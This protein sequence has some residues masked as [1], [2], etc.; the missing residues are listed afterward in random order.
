MR[1]LYLVTL[2][3]LAAVAT[4]NG[5]C[6]GSAGGGKATGDYLT[7]GICVTTSTCNHVSDVT[8]FSFDLL[9]SGPVQENDS[10]LD[11]SARLL[12]TVFPSSKF[13]DASSTIPTN[14]VPLILSQYKGHYIS[15]GCPYDDN[16]V[17]CCLIGLDQSAA[18]KSLP[19]FPSRILLI[20][21]QPIPI[22]E[23]PN[24]TASPSNPPKGSC[25]FELPSPKA[26]RPSQKTELTQDVSRS[27]P[28]RRLFLL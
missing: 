10:V 24:L 13:P 16:D 12:R 27:Q 6:S 4:L 9:P 19:S 22:T 23:S 1:S 26:T 11:M 25:G 14:N 7:D 18:S 17:K 3:P 5:H 15:N 28:L 2:F 20:Q 21:A 8:V